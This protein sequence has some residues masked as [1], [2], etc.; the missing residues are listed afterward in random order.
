MTPK[1]IAD[2]RLARGEITLEEHKR[3]VEQLAPDS[4]MN[5]K[6]T[7]QATSMDQPATVAP[8]R[9]FSSTPLFK[10]ATYAGT[11]VLLMGLATLFLRNQD[12][13]EF[14]RRCDTTLV[15]VGVNCDCF[16]SRMRSQLSFAW[17]IP[18]LRGMI[19]PSNAEIEM[20]MARSI[21]QCRR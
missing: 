2:S 16:E 15:A 14:R 17:Y 1:E 18:L 13:N 12:A 8:R 7:A 11:F 6:F 10:V 5:R 4:T 3:I 21:A 9:A 19:R 20:M